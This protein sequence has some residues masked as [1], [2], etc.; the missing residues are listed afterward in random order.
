MPTAIDKAMEIAKQKTWPC[1]K[2]DP[3]RDKIIRYSCPHRWGV[4]EVPEWC[5]DRKKLKKTCR[6]C[7]EQ[8]YKE[9]HFDPASEKEPETKEV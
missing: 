5:K 9:K 6:D 7:W 1:P 3:D 4:G 8:E 2:M